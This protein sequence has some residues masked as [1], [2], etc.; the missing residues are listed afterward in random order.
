MQNRISVAAAIIFR[1]DLRFLIGRK[2]RG[3]SHEG[4]WEFPGGKCEPFEAPSEAV[5][6]E[7]REELF[8]T[9][10]INH[11]GFYSYPFEYPE[12]NLLVEF[13]FFIAAALTTACTLK[14]HD[15]IAWVNPEDVREYKL[16]PGD[17]PAMEYLMKNIQSAYSLATSLHLHSV[18]NNG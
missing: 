18:I 3:L 17:V 6:R 12:K 1:N 13:H 9:V 5:V 11:D 16:L 7:I 8:I 14:D 2:K 10:R 15:Q 4:L